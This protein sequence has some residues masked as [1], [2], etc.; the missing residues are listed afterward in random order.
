VPGQGSGVSWH[1]FAMLVGLDDVKPDR[2]VRRFVAGALGR[3][4][5]SAEDARALVIETAI[6]FGVS[7]RALDYAI[8]SHVSHR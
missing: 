7:P 6:G 5:V 2:M 1:A 4:T 3:A 8:W